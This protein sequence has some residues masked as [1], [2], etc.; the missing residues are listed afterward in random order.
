MP[1]KDALPIWLKLA[2][3]LGTPVIAANYARTYGLKNFLWLS[4]IALGCTTAA[5]LTD[6]RLLA[7]MP[8]VG[9]LPLETAW[10]ASFLSGGK[11]TGLAG[12]MF[13]RHIPL[14]RRALSLFHLA[15]P[16]TI[17]WILHRFGYDRRALALQTAV[18]WVVLPVTYAVTEP[19]K[20]INW[21]FGPGSKPQ[22]RLPPLL[23]LGL[24]MVALPA[25][26]FLPMHRLLCRLF[27]QHEG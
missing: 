1:G 8:A 16:P 12:Y 10:T 25:L 7:S 24:E 6:N 21:V 14:G 9:V 3:G 27:G 5:V 26:V 13:D 15:L 4:D 23:Y 22:H 17:L 11:L 20:N 18:T 2:Y 19:E